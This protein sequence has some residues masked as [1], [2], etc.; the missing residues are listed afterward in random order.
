[1]LDTF[2]LMSPKYIIQKLVCVARA[3]NNGQLNTS[4]WTVTGVLEPPLSNSMEFSCHHDLCDIAWQQ[5]NMIAFY[6]LITQY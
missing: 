2:D 5:L 3:P 6:L 4:H 1:M